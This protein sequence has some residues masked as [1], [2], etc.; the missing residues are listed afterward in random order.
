MPEPEA[1][2]FLGYFFADIRT[3]A[4]QPLIYER[5]GAIY[6]QI[7]KRETIAMISAF[8][9]AIHAA[10]IV[11]GDRIAFQLPASANFWVSEWGVL[12]NRATAMII[13]QS[14]ELHELGEILAENG[15]RIMLIDTLAA[16][17]AIADMAPTLPHLTQIICMEGGAQSAIPIVSWPDFIE[18]GRSLPDRSSALL[19]SITAKDT[20]LLFYYKDDNNVRQA[21]RYSHT[22]LLENARRMNALIASRTELHPGD[23][24]LTAPE[25]DNALGHIM[26]CYVPLLRQSAIQIAFTG[27]DMNVFDTQ[28]GVIVGTAS[29]F[30]SLRQY[31]I[32]QVK[33]SGR[34]E[35]E[36]LTTALSFSKIKYESATKKKLSFLQKAL[37]R[38]MQYTIVKKVKALL[39]NKL[40][41]LIGIDDEAHYDLEL[42]FHTFGI[43]LIELQPDMLG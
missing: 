30:E 14:F 40:H 37:D 28:P 29:Y 7:S 34:L 6:Q 36:M 41:V 15:A 39:G 13:P 9:R 1:E 20:A 11:A 33:T 25:W 27:G 24:F 38:L 8:A 5:K 17:I 31:I 22:M 21:L 2:H 42:F 43:E 19:R 35:F 4:Q 32:E 10:G 16:A 3:N 23:I 26:S 12:A 18:S